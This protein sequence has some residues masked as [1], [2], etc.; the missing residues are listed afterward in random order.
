ML[1]FALRTRSILAVFVL[2]VFPLFGCQK[3]QVAGDPAA[4]RQLFQSGCAVCHYANAAQ[5]KVGPG[6]FGL[7]QAKSLPDGAAVTDTN[8]E[9]WIRNGGGLMPGFANALTPKQMRDLI[10]YLKTL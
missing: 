9:H 5:K 2:S 8:V 3:K 10:A 1:E 6:L 4:G 7:Y